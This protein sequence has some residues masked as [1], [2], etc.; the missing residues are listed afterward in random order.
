M[1]RGRQISDEIRAQVIAELLTGAG[2]NETAR[3]YQ[4]GAKTVSRIKNEIAPEQLTQLDT[5][6][7][8]RIDDLLL[9]SVATH[10]AALDRIA[11]YVSQ[12]E[13]IAHKEPQHIAALYREIKDTPLSILEA[14]SAAEGIESSGEEPD[15]E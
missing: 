2:V 12:P 1:A 8:N 10:L 11:N 13:Y 7:R 4:L 5:E 14:A 3:K 15:G 6:K 9:D